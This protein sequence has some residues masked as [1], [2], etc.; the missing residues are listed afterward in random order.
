L[1]PFYYR[2]DSNFLWYNIDNLIVLLGNN[3][4]GI[5]KAKVNYSN[6]YIK[7]VEPDTGYFNSLETLINLIT[8]AP[9]FS[10]NRWYNINNYFEIVQCLHNYINTD[11]FNIYYTEF[12]TIIFH[13]VYSQSSPLCHS[14]VSIEN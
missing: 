9:P 5:F 3:D 8:L 14:R 10:F 13:S 12:K 2:I 6:L 4:L 7:N 11:G 1:L